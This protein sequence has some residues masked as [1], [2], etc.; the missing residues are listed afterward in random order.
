MRAWFCLAV[1]LCG[2]SKSGE[3][4]ERK[5]VQPALPI[6]HPPLNLPPAP[7]QGLAGR[8]PIRVSVEQLRKSIEAVTGG[9]VWKGTINGDPNTDMLKYL[10]RTLGEADFSE[11]T[12]ENR[13]PGI[14]FSKFVDDGARRVCLDVVTLDRNRPAAEKVL[15]RSVSAADDLTSN[16]A[17]VMKN[18]AYLRLRFLGD[19]EVNGPQQGET[20]LVFADAVRFNAT[21][22]EAWLAVCVSLLS[23]PRF[24]AY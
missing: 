14:L 19:D 13:E 21:T 9:V 20:A 12:Q 17:A 15:M 4:A 2:C 23:D 24:I 8:A 3:V 22:E 1:M 5:V 6:D 7:L 16:R 10:A 11:V 18:V